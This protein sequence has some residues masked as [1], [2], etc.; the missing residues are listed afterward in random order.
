MKKISIIIPVYNKAPFLARC[1]DSVALQPK[2]LIDVIIVDD[3]STDG[4]GAICDD[5]AAKFGWSVYHTENNGVSEARNLGIDKVRT[6]YFTFLDADDALCEDA[7]QAYAK[8]SRVGANIAQFGHYRQ[9][10]VELIDRRLQMPYRA[11]EG[12]YSFEYIPKYWVMV[13]NKL[14]KTSFIRDNNIRFRKG[15]Q[16][17]E[18]TVFNMECILA[19]N[20][21]YHSQYATI[22]HLLD[23]NNSLCRGDLKKEQLL[24]LDE[25]MCKIADA[26]KDA[27]KRAWINKAINE[28]RGS[29]LYK[30]LGADRGFRG[31]HDIVYFVKDVAENEELR[32]SLRS[33]EENWRYKNVWFC[34]EC[35]KGL[36][37]DKLM[38]VKQVGLNKWEKV[39]N[40]IKQVCENDNI[41]EDFWLFNDDFFVLKP[42][43]VNVEPP[44]N[45]RLVPYV[46]GIEKRTGSA[47]EYT[48]R[49]RE[50]A[51]VLKDKGF[52]TLNY[53]VHKPILIN[54]KKAL[55]VLDYF[56]NTPA[57]RSLYGNY[58]KIGG[59]DKHDMKIRIMHYNRM[60]AVRYAW[61]FVSTCDTSFADGEVGMFI[62]E[63]FNKKSRFERS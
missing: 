26:E 28:H 12:P 18:D 1:L 62:R 51:K 53:E 56:S 13:W 15:M 43:P 45:G 37:P 42:M 55:E 14:Y 31:D 22:Y 46:D 41:S 34:G 4:S 50:A 36:K 23:D 52:D 2:Y 32:Y 59:E 17:G 21:F 49:L 9:K 35:P 7:A 38:A 5:Y 33:V 61:D 16:F 3:G 29:R 60:D 25:E 8:I 6:E 44:Y 48:I 10:V 47:N 57:F 40:M 63:K 11:P 54:R 58:W 27:A 39:R 20:G 24:K 30:K 19:N